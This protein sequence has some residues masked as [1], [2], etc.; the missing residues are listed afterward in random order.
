MKSF[1]IIFLVAFLIV[2]TV[3]GYA[4]YSSQA[5]GGSGKTTMF[6]RFSDWI[7]TAGKSQEEKYRIKAQRRAYRKI[8]RA[9]KRIARQKRNYLRK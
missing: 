7:A 9:K 4:Q 6:N 1:K 3:P 5:Y 8:Q 2:Q